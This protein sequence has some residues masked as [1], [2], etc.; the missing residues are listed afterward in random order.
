[1]A[2]TAPRKEITLP[3]SATK[4]TIRRLGPADYTSVGGIPDP[5]IEMGMKQRRGER[6]EV[7]DLQKLDSQSLVFSQSLAIAAIFKHPEGQRIVYKRPEECNEQAGEFSFFDMEA[8]DQEYLVEE[9]FKFT[10][11]GVASATAF[12][13]AE[14]HGADA[15][16]AG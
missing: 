7:K 10:G 3:A 5:L 6:L 1:M 4:L 14:E 15:A 8:S 13:K 9:V 12:P 11:E 16:S 2:L